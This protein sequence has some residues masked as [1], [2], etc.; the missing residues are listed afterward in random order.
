MLSAAEPK[1]IDEPPGPGRIRAGMTA[2]EVKLAVGPPQRIARQILYHRY[3]EQWLYLNPG[4]FRV[5][6]DAPRGQ[7]GRVISVHL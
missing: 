2:A 4:P 3:L 7:A 6:F 1:P 5:E